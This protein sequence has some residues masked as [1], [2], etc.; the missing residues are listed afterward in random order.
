MPQYFPTALWKVG[1]DPVAPAITDFTTC[2]YGVGFG[3]T[4]DRT[5]SWEAWKLENSLGYLGDGDMGLA[6]CSQQNYP[7]SAAVP[8]CLGDPAKRQA[9]IQQFI[10]PQVKQFKQ[11]VSITPP[12]SP[13]WCECWLCSPRPYIDRIMLLANDA[14]AAIPSG[15]RVCTLAYSNYG[16]PPDKIQPD[17][18][19]VVMVTNG[20]QTSGLSTSEILWLWAKKT[21]IRDFGVYVYASDFQFNR[22]VWG[23]MKGA[24]WGNAWAGNPEGMASDLREWHARGSRH[25][26][27][28]CGDD[29]ALCGLGY[30]LLGQL[31]RDLGKT[32]STIRN[33]FAASCFNS[34]STACAFFDLVTGHPLASDTDRAYK[35]L[36]QLSVNTSDLVPSASR[37]RQLALGVRYVELWLKYMQTGT[38]TDFEALYYHAQRSNG[39]VHFNAITE[40]CG[41]DGIDKGVV[42]PSGTATPVPYEDSEIDAFVATGAALPQGPPS[43]NWPD[44]S[45][46]IRASVDDTPNAVGADNLFYVPLGTKTV[47]MWAFVAGAIGD[48]NGN[49]A[50]TFPGPRNIPD[51]YSIPVPTGLDGK[52]WRVEYSGLL[53][54][55]NIPPYL[56]QNP[57][58]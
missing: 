32:P 42:S 47:E 41:P 12:D 1:P 24:V 52:W 7:S 33:D 38:Q 2:C 27:A 55:I 49:L 16:L 22:G 36:L 19:I 13:V 29:W 46:G 25:I 51:Y 14:Q 21:E 35:I 28:E 10:L 57:A 43:D 48:P 8:L 37:I 44:Y 53:A 3:T 26:V 4:P 17:R 39:M 9:L 31:A 54:F 34:A 20:Q 6:N 15:Y 11:S 40:L 50:F 5:E 30:Y 58:A 23:N 18:R 56:F 45:K